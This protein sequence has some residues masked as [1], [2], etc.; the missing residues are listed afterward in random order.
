M[1]IFVAAEFALFLLGGV[2]M[3]SVAVLVLVRTIRPREKP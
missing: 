1:V 3:A 2:W